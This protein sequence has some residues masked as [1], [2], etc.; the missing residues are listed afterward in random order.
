MLF[1]P[2]AEVLEK[3]NQNTDQ[4]YSKDTCVFILIV[5]ILSMNDSHRHIHSYFARLLI[6]KVNFYEGIL[7][8]FHYLHQPFDVHKANM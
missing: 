2:Y 4:K 7:S 6:N 5:D 1:T 8:V 3:F